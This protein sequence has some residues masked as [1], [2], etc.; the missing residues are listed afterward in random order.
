MST[1]CTHDHH[2]SILLSQEVL[3]SPSSHQAKD[4][5]TPST[6][7]RSHT[8]SPHLYN[9]TAVPGTFKLWGDCARDCTSWQN[10]K[11]ITF[12]CF[13]SFSSHIYYDTQL[14]LCYCP[15]LHLTLKK[16]TYILVEFNTDESRVNELE[17]QTTGLYFH[18]MKLNDLP[19]L[20][21]NLLK[22]QMFCLPDSE[23]LNSV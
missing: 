18:Q 5:N 22:I 11:T 6:G 15:V 13:W 7:H 20:H 19:K 2:L 16:S 14:V 21:L 1:R 8:L 3:V 12:V 17:S 4:G 9:L 23:T 10:V